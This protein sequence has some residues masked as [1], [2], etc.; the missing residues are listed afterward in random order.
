MVKLRRDIQEVT[1]GLCLGWKNLVVTYLKVRRWGQMFVFNQETKWG[2]KG[3][4]LL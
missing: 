1:A 4:L 3:I 2:K